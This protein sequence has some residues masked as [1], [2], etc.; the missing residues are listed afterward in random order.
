M[1]ILITGGTGLLGRSLCTKL[2]QAGHDPIVLSRDA[3]AARGRLPSGVQL[4]QWQPGA[5]RV[6]LAALEGV[7]AVINLAGE[8]IGVGRWTASRKQLI[9][10]S[11][12]GITRALVEGFQ[13][14]SKPPRV[15]I[16]GSAIG[17]Y[18]PCGDEELTEASSPGNDFLAKVC[19]AWEQEANRAGE[20]GVRV[21]T[22]R[23][24]IVLSRE[25]GTLPRMVTPFRL[26]IGGPLGSGRQW[27]SW[28]HIADAI[29]IIKLALEHTTVAGPLNLTAP[30]PVRMEEF[31]SVLGRVL[32]RPSSLRVPAWVLKMALGEMAALLLTGQRV[33]PARALQEGYQFR[34]P[35][36][37]G[38][39]EDLL[40]SSRHERKG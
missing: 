28:I 21:V 12:V 4:I 32:K 39:L 11:R 23:T 31:A 37:A 22:I 27:V 19:R 33:L 26:F 35:E 9:M 7:E 18:G 13:G 2:L 1:K 24:G 20:L 38:A 8:N 5:E 3:A 40:I 16:S 14:L 17:Y 34:Y 15:F 10:Q 6:P 30:R 25:G 29:G 36:L